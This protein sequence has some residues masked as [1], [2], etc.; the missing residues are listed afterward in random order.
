MSYKPLYYQVLIKAAGNKPKQNTKPQIKFD[1]NVQFRNTHH[2]FYQPVNGTSM[3]F[4]SLM[5]LVSIP[6]WGLVMRQVSLDILNF[7]SLGYKLKSEDL[8]FVIGNRSEKRNNTEKL[9]NSEHSQVF[10]DRNQYI[11]LLYK[12]TTIRTL[13]ASEDKELV[14][15]NS[16]LNPCKK[17]I[18]KEV[19]NAVE[20]VI[21]ALFKACISGDEYYEITGEDIQYDYVSILK[22]LA[23]FALED[24]VKA[25]TTFISKSLITRIQQMTDEEKTELFDIKQPAQLRPNVRLTPTGSKIE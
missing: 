8:M 5:N 24:V 3:I 13:K 9:E 17:I 4:G 12:G 15:L 22:A 18:R 23:E 7:L 2:N 16:Y 14:I 11:A 19:K 1:P 25:E 20:T 21:S 10:A 6:H